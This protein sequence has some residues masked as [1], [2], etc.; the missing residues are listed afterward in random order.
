MIHR[1]SIHHAQKVVELRI[2]IRVVQG[3]VVDEVFGV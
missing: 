3:V 2:M 1:A